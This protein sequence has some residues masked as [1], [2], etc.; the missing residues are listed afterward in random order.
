MENKVCQ[1]CNKDFIVYE[2]DKNFY[3]KIDVPSPMFCPDC[4]YQ[5]RLINR[6]EWNF[7]R[8]VCTFCHKSI[9]SIHN[10]TYKGAVYCQKCW[11]SDNWDPF[12]YGQEY[13]FSKSFFEQYALLQSQVPR[14]AMVSENS[15]N[16]EYTNQAQN[17]KNC[18]FI[19]AS[20]R[21]EDC[22][23]G[24]WNVSSKEC[25]D[26]YMVEKCELLYESINCRQCYQSSYLYNC[27][28]CVNSA[29]MYDCV[30]CT[31]CFGCTGL[32]KKQYCYFNEQLT[33]EEYSQ[34][35]KSFVWDRDFIDETLAHF[36][37]FVKKYPHKYY[38]GLKNSQVTG[39]YIEN[40]ADSELIFNCRNS[41]DIKYS[42]DSY[43]AQ[44][45]YDNTETGFPIDR[46]YELQG[47]AGISRSIVLRSCWT[48]ND[49]GYCDL[50]FGNND[51]FGC[52]GLR[53]KKYCIFNKQYSKDEYTILKGKII[54]HM[55]STK[56]WG[57]YTPA[58]ISLFSYNESLAQEYFPLTKE[59]VKQ[60]GFIWYERPDREYSITRRSEDLPGTISETQNEIIK[61]IIECSSQSTN[62]GKEKYTECTTA[63]RVTPE[64]I[65][66]YR[67]MN[68][69]LPYKCFPCRR[70]DRF[71]LRN[72]RKLWS[73]ECMCN[74]V[75]HDHVDK[76]SNT[77]ETSYAP[78]RQEI[79]Y[80]ESCYQKEV[81]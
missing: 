58:S 57:E 6:N 41:K 14:L 44:D 12:S 20:D 66:L 52:I 69:P 30:G 75:N 46:S 29:F 54:E 37:E 48:D 72:P 11:W 62:E 76:C 27:H 49:C 2:N 31:D 22:M 15:V 50:C 28:D 34:K 33:K 7:Y 10:E 78:E 60:Q 64:E 63:F 25:M 51:L 45:S 79:I 9:I 59:E 8:R 73:R 61:E 16:S 68:I 38:N 71:S 42:Q 80:C 67:K 19:I 55:K 35:I 70:V 3:A 13:D 24:N 53:G 21:C 5:R 39:D 81:M 23:Y 40:C 77:L 36:F 56:E 47:C 32:R 26:C 17:N 4:R 65:L 43:Y 18:Y 74:I 1:N